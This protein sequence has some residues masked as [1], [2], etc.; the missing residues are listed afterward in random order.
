MQDPLLKKKA[1]QM[2]NL[3]F[4]SFILSLLLIFAQY[5]E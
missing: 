3:G 2:Y 4:K 5:E 1:F